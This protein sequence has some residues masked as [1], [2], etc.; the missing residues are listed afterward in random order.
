MDKIKYIAT[1]PFV[2]AVLLVVGCGTANRSGEITDFP[3]D[4]TLIMAGFVWSPPTSFNPLNEDPTCPM[5][6]DCFL[7]YEPM[8][9]YNMLTGEMEGILGTSYLFSKDTL[10]VQLNERAAWHDGSMLTSEDV[11]YTFGLHKKYNTNLHSDCDYFDD[12]K[13]CGP[14][15]VKF[16]LNTKKLNPLIMQEIIGTALIIPKKAF[17]PLEQRCIA[18][19]KTEKKGKADPDDIFEKINAFKNDSM[20]LSSGPYSLYTYS[21]QKIVVKRFDSY[22]GNVLHGGAMPKPEYIIFPIFKSNEA[23]NVALSQGN[24][25][26]SVNFVPQIY[27]RF[28]KGVGTWYKDKP[29]FVPGTI[30]CMLMELTKK[31]FSDVHFR[32]AVA[33]AVNYEQIRKLSIYGYAPP[34]KPG[35]IIPFGPEKKYYNDSDAVRYGVSY[36]PGKAREILKAAGYKWGDDSLLIGPDG[37]KLETVYATCPNGWTDWESAARI[38]VTGLRAVGVDVHE[39]FVEEAIW[40]KDLLNGNFD[41]TMYQT[42]DY[43][44]IATPW[45]RFYKTMGSFEWAPPG[46]VMYIDVQRYKNPVADSLLLLLPTLKDEKSISE[47]YRS[48]N[49]KFMQDL[50]VVPLMYRPWFFY[51][52]SK[53]HWSNFPTADNPYSPPQCLIVGAGIKGLWNINPLGK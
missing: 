13:A 14:H 3:R 20:P 32:Q 18:E 6:G 53:K 10:I 8:F 47:V 4:K 26:L 35:L 30:A 31:P 50:P 40:W 46:E 36:D 11:V 27:N 17:Y 7:V 12:I 19:V 43:E 23:G 2:C 9:G 24:V 33:H 34:L 41:I 22:W 38:L 1:L 37:N 28:K 25:D 5:T 29:Y 52:F 44:S 45:E 15:C 21:D 48:L 16:L 51:E 49:I 42:L 39:K